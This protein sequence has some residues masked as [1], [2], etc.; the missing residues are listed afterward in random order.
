MQGTGREVYRG[1][2]GGVMSTQDGPALEFTLDWPHGHMTRDGKD[3]EIFCER[4]GALYGRKRISGV[5]W[6]AI[7]RCP[8]GRMYDF[9]KQPG[10]IINRPAPKPAPFK[11]VGWGALSEIG[12]FV[13]LSSEQEAC[14]TA[15]EKWRAVKVKITEIEE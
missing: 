6:M 12:S 7:D 15:T 4:D 8:N 11:Y 1:W 13:P 2:G 3:V 9:A 14:Q 5:E 10:D